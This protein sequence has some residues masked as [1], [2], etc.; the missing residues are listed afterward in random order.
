MTM[1]GKETQILCIN[2][3]YPA[4]K[5]NAVVDD[6]SVLYELRSRRRDEVVVIVGPSLAKS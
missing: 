2:R 4:E 3:V 1:V 5:K 6:L